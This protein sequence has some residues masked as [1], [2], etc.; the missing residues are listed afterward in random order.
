MKSALSL[1]LTLFTFPVRRCPHITWLHFL[2]ASRIPGAALR[3]S[4]PSSPNP[5][6]HGIDFL[7]KFDGLNPS[8]FRFP[9]FQVNKTACEGP[10]KTQGNIRKVAEMCWFSTI[11]SIQWQAQGGLDKEDDVRKISAEIFH[12]VTCS[13]VVPQSF[14]YCNLK[15]KDLQIFH[16]DKTLLRWRG[17]TFKLR[18]ENV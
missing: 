1:G 5:V 3:N 7:I 11:T 13:Y 17:K 4:L 10:G 9:L 14:W 8:F 2:N 15:L 16:H 18:Y 6:V 12:L